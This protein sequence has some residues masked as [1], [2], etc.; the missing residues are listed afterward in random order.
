M[1]AG[2]EMKNNSQPYFQ[3]TQMK[4]NSIN[5]SGSDVG[6]LLLHGFT[7]TTVEVGKLANLFIKDGF[8][9]S[10]PLLPGHNTTPKELNTV[11]YSD[12][13]RCVDSAYQKIRNT[14]RKVLVCGESM[15]GVL[16]LMLAQKYCEIDA[17]FCFSA[18]LLVGRLRYSKYIMH[19]QPFLDKNLPEDGLPWQGYT[20]YPTRAANEFFKLTKQVKRSLSKVIS[21]TLLFQ[22]NFDKTIDRENMEFIFH[23]IRSPIKQM[24]W[25]PASGH[26]MLLDN[27]LESI[28]GRIGKFISDHQILEPHAGL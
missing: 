19:F 4:G 22:G 8:T 25:M 10:A 2:L 27:E 14:C 24:E 11:K 21:P 26:V 15:G 9:V 5:H 12:W 17:V 20:V 23:A 3:N 6:V 28:Y 13:V 7:A 16:S 1:R 18:A